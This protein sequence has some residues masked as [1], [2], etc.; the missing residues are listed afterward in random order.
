MEKTK[1][2]GVEVLTLQIKLNYST[3]YQTIEGF[4]ASG[5]WWAQDVGGWENLSEI[6]EYLY[7]NEKGIGLNIYRYNIGAGEPSKPWDPWRKTQTVEVSPGVYDLNRD[8]NAITALKEAVKCGA[9]TVVLFANSPPARLT[10]S[11]NTSGEESGKSNLAEGKEHEFAKYLVDITE[12]ILNEG[13]PVKYL[14]P[15]NEP[16][17]DWKSGQEGCHYE[18]DEVIKL[19]R[20][21]VL[22]LE[23]R[24]LPVKISIP[25]SGKWY[26]E[27][28]TLTLY[29]KVMDD[30][31][32][33]RAIDHWAVHSYWSDEKDKKKAAIY[34][35]QIKDMVPLHQTEWCEM[36]N[37]RNFGMDAALVMATT[38]HEDMTILSVVSW[39]HWL[40]VSC[41]DYRDGVVYVDIPTHKYRLAKRAWALGNYAKFIDNGYKRIGV[42]CQD[43]EI[44]VSAYVNPVGEET[45][46]VVINPANNSKT[47]SFSEIKSKNI[48]VYETSEN[49]DCELVDTISKTET[50][51]I[52]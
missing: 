5:C 3:T 49:Y 29:K 40:A 11:G 32:L 37:G 25:E 41:Y 22:E 6:I 17:W 14:S 48:K 47:I 36:V 44:K 20:E 27:R 38:I 16:Q 7:D 19:A 43:N 13:I 35:S 9:D 46:I 10:K 42:E 24:N 39:S 30:E 4:G 26:D 12:L 31:I 1:E 51:T 34:F 23:K 2:G 8:K 45:V 15:I 33:S 21:V 18:P 50:W 52:P 28:Y